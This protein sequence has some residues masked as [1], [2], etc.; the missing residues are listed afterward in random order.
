MTGSYIVAIMGCRVCMGECWLPGIQILVLA[1]RPRTACLCQT[2]SPSPWSPIIQLWE[3]E[4]GGGGGLN[5]CGPVGK[6]C[7]VC[8]QSRDLAENLNGLSEGIHMVWRAGRNNVHRPPSQ[9]RMSSTWLVRLW[10][11]SSGEALQPPVILL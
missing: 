6:G 8:S 5:Y 4:P 1:I 9:R 7:T 11:V 10:R 2:D 3:G